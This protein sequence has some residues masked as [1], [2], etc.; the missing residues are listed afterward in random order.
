MLRSLLG[1][2]GCFPDE[3][4]AALPDLPHPFLY[5]KGKAPVAAA[6]RGAVMSRATRMS[7]VPLGSLVG[8]GPV[9]LSAREGQPGCPGPGVFRRSIHHLSGSTGGTEATV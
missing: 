6:T 5:A 7:P 2:Q 1:S 3:R 9:H 4:G 8:E